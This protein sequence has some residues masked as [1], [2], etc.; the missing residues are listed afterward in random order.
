MRPRACSGVRLHRGTFAIEL[1][2]RERPRSIF[3]DR[4]SFGPR[5]RVDRW[6]S[7]RAAR[8][9]L[10]PANQSGG[11]DP[12]DFAAR[13]GLSEW[14]RRRLAPVVVERDTGRICCRVGRLLGSAFLVVSTFTGNLDSIGNRSRDPM[15][16][17]ER[18]DGGLH[19]GWRGGF[20]NGGYTCGNDS[21]GL[22]HH[23]TIQRA[24]D[25]WNRSGQ[26]L[27]RVVRRAVLWPALDRLRD[28]YAARSTS[29]LGDGDAT[30]AASEAGARGVAPVDARRHP[31]GDC[32]HLGEAEF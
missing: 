14:F 30:V 18:D 19:Q 8:C 29:V 23:E 2:S 26:P 25:S 7:V 32:A 15:R 1:A 9:R 4:R 31:A 5:G 17:T 6:I 28:R 27:R 13:F 10:V 21:R 20:S 12:E 24:G 3:H 22:D 16:R 11:D